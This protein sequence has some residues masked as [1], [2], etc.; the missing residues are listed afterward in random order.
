VHRRY[1]IVVPKP[2]PAAMLVVRR[3]YLIVMP[4]PVPRPLTAA[5]R[6]CCSRIRKPGR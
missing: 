2:L 4:R 5:T 3:T 1:L 6:R